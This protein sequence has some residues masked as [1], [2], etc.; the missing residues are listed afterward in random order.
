MPNKE[1]EPDAYQMLIDEV[2]ER[3]RREKAAAAKAAEA[4]TRKY[5]KLNMAS[6]T[7]FLNEEGRKSQQKIAEQ[8]Q[9]EA[10]AKSAEEPCIYKGLDKLMA[11]VNE[12]KEAEAK[13]EAEMSVCDAP[14]PCLLPTSFGRA[15]KEA[16]NLISPAVKTL[17]KKSPRLMDSFDKGRAWQQMTSKP[18]WWQRLGLEGAP[19]APGTESW[20][21]A[22]SRW[23]ER[24]IAYSN[25]AQNRTVNPTIVGTAQER[26]LAERVVQAAREHQGH[27]QSTTGAYIPFKTREIYFDTNPASKDIARGTLGSFKNQRA[28]IYPTQHGDTTSLIGTIAHEVG[29]HGMDG[30]VTNIPVVFRGQNTYPFYAIQQG[31]LGELTAESTAILLLRKMIESPKGS[32]LRHQLDRALDSCR[33]RARDP[34][35]YIRRSVSKPLNAIDQQRVGPNNVPLSDQDAAHYLGQM[36]RL[37]DF[38]YPAGRAPYSGVTKMAPDGVP[39]APEYTHAFE[40]YLGQVVNDALKRQWGG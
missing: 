39:V 20:V 36:S 1:D 21:P 30:N 35:N 40:D 2:L 13:K 6:A 15:K 17:F 8:K 16:A 33:K 29:G 27:V 9:K 32:P 24:R 12:N 22:P 25:P 10:A 5:P 26:E 28:T 14:T 23:W 31:G 11:L 38:V 4:A 34:A 3:G 19:P 37:D 18:T 7:E